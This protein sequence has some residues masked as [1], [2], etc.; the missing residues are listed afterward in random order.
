LA[1][2]SFWYRFVLTSISWAVTLS[3]CPLAKAK[4]IYNSSE[5]PWAFW[6]GSI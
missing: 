1:T 5:R 4:Y 2:V 6:W 3:W